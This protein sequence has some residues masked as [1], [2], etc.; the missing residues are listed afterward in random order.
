[1]VFINNAND[2]VMPVT[3]DLEA[4]K[5]I[6]NRM[7]IL[8]N[9]YF[10]QLNL[11]N[12]P[13]SDD[14]KYL[15]NALE[16]VK[17]GSNTLYAGDGGTTLR[18]LMA[19]A[20]VQN[21]EITINASPSLLKRP[22]I[23]LVKALNNS[24]FDIRFG[25]NFEIRPTDLNTI[26]P[27]WQIDVTQSS[28]F[29]SALALIAPAMPFDVVIDLKGNSVSSSYL[30]MTIQL[31]QFMGLSIKKIGNKITS[32]PFQKSYQKFDFNIESD[33]SAAS[34]FVG[35]AILERRELIIQNISKS[36]LQPDIAILKFAETLGVN[37]S[38]EEN[39]IILK[40]FS[41]FNFPTKIIRDYTLCPDIYPTEKVICHLLNIELI[42]SG[43]EHL[44]H[45]ESNRVDVLNLEL[46]KL[47][48]ENP[49][50]DT[51]HD[52]RIAM[53]LALCA[54]RKNIKIKNPEVVSKSFPDFWNQFK[55][56]GF[57]ISEI[58]E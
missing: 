40:P 28:Q 20:M 12:I 44:Q 52:H 56:L 57:N 24:G 36:V 5:S 10:P 38:F 46:Q 21:K 45:K 25:E 22:F 6:A 2:S 33:W 47:V 15:F 35:F 37:H 53:S 26:K 14:T 31:M 7:I 34:Y 30:D 27:R 29:A 8:Q 51:H 4:S 54:A 19:W 13:L 50:F 48:L 11:Y 3:I 1:M 42:A 17:T 55:K 16:N 49:V 9:L 32:R 43:I 58:G 18:F 41:N 39:R 23:E